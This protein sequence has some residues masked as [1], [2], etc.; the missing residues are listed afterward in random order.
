MPPRPSD[1]ALRKLIADLAERPKADVRAVLARLRP[2]QRERAEELIAEFR[3]RPVAR[4]VEPAS[5]VVDTQGLSPWLA[6]R[7]QVA[8]GGVN[9]GDFTMTPQALDALQDVSSVGVDQ[10]SRAVAPVGGLGDALFDA[11]SR[12]LGGPAR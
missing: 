10:R 3:G 9:G 1:R 2:L 6:A 4:P 12:W 8:A 5:P 7:V 11:V